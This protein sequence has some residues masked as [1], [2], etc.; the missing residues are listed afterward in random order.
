[1]PDDEIKSEI[2]SIAG[3]ATTAALNAIDNKTPDVSSLVKKTDCDTKIS[4]IGSTYFNSS[5]YDKF[6]NNVL[7]AE[8]LAK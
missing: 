2:P 7:D 6:I 4:D 3:L 5:D 1:M 8:T